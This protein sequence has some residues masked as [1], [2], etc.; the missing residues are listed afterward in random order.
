MQLT[1]YD[2]DRHYSGFSSPV[3]KLITS[4]I[5]IEDMSTEVLR[6]NGIAS[7]NSARLQFENGIVVEGLV[8]EILRG[9][10]GKVIL[11]EWQ[12]ARL[13]YQEIDLISAPFY[14][15]AVGE[16]IVSAYAGPADVEA[17]QPTVRVPHEKMHKILY[18]DKAIQLQELYGSVRAARIGS[19][20]VARLPE[21]WRSVVDGF[22][23]DW[24]LS[25][26]ILEILDGDDSYQLEA[27]LI[28]KY[29]EEKSQAMPH[30]EN[31]ILN[32]L[33]LIGVTAGS[34][35]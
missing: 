22:P 28:R 26:E 17:F 1:G 15:M 11:L 30:L 6:R 25:L 2:K 23:G 9:R 8:V 10:S 14:S 4:P 20:A 27:D 3:G 35:R 32:G 19:T 34:N 12:D 18:D 33:K 7:G 24:L 29:L 5:P 21:I 31:L 13:Q 16:K